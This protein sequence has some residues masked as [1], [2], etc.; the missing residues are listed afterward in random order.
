MLAFCTRLLCCAAA[1]LALAGCAATNAAMGGNTPK[2]A[3]AEAR[4]DY[5]ADG[6]VLDVS[7]DAALNFYAGQSHTVLLGVYQVAEASSFRQLMADPAA[8][9]GTLDSGAAGDGVLSFARYVIAPGTRTIIKLDRAQHAKFIGIGAGYYGLD[10]DGAMRLFEVPLAMSSRGWVSTTYSAAPSALMLQ[11][12]LGAAR[13]VN[14]TQMPL[15][16]EQQRLLE[17]A[18]GVQRAPLRLPAPDAAPAL[19]VPTLS[20]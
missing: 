18:A 8:T 5:T 1:T 6:I 2:L 3:Q 9:A 17:A 19:P 15:G 11:L 20:R 4:W 7:A 14:A 10:G 13:I 16:P 12:R